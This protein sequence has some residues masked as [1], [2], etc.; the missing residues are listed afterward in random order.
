ME[1]LSKVCPRAGWC[2]PKSVCI[3][4]WAD[5]LDASDDFLDV[6]LVL[7]LVSILLLA[8]LRPTSRLI[9]STLRHLLLLLL[10][11]SLSLVHL[12]AQAVHPAL[13]VRLPLLVDTHLE[14]LL[15]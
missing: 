2:L 1:V 9:T 10:G 13:E 6:V 15:V 8:R 14:Q 7:T 11:L 5:N 12:S 4:L 3:E